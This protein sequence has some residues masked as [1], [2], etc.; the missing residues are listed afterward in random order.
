MLTTIDC[1]TGGV[2]VVYERENRYDDV[3]KLISPDHLVG[4]T[5]DN[6][7]HFEA[8]VSEDSS[9]QDVLHDDAEKDESVSSKGE[10]VAEAERSETAEDEIAEVGE[11][12][13]NFGL[14]DDNFG[15]DD[16]DAGSHLSHT[17]RSTFAPG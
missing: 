1:K 6:T 3:E 17:T 2:Y 10:T 16:A 8:T 4:V 5:V 13:S 12:L 9:H 14:V 11:S 7:T 15:R